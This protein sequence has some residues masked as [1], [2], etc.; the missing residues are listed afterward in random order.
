MIANSFSG[1]FHIGLGESWVYVLASACE[2]DCE[3]VKVCRDVYSVRGVDC[4]FVAWGYFYV[5]G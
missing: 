3:G 2:A 4:A 1:C 5:E